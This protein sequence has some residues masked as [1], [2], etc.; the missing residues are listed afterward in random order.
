[1]QNI[2]ISVENL[3]Y[4]YSETPVLNKIDL[5]IN[6]KSLTLILG[7]NGSGKTTLA[8]CLV[9]L[10]QPVEG[11]IT[12]YSD[13]IGYVSQRNNIGS[14]F[15]INVDEVVSTGWLLGTKKIF[16]RKSDREKTVDHSLKSVGM[17]EHKQSLI[18]ELSGG[19]QQRVMIAKAL[20]SEPNILILDEPTLGVDSESIEKIIS[21]IEHIINKHDTT[22]IVI[23]HEEK[24]FAKLADKVIKLDNEVIFE[25]TYSQY[26]N[27]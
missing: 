14:D 26:V 24:Y 10:L 25:G 9:G 20:A 15:P 8:K 27:I 3:R 21:A 17:L 2:A 1:M 19:Q 13:K 4:S 6:Q 5:E 12:R 23:T 7:N 16:H 22:V 11:A 18:S